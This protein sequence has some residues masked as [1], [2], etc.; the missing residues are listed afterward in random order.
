MGATEPAEP[1]EDPHEAEGS[2]GGNASAQGSGGGRLAE[3]D[4]CLS[5]RGGAGR[6][7]QDFLESARWLLGADAPGLVCR[8]EAVAYCVREAADSI[9][10]S[11]GPVTVDSP[12]K[13]LSQRVVD[14]R[15]RYD[16]AVRFPGEGSSEAALADLLG[17]IDALEEF[18]QEW[19]TLN[20]V[21][22][23]EVNARL[24]GSP[25]QRG[26][27]APMFE[28]LGVHER[29]SVF[30][31]SRSSLEDAER[32]LW[33]CVDSMLGLLRSPSDRE[34]QMAEV[35]A[36]ACPG[37]DDLAEALRRIGT[38][39]DLDVFLDR[40]C[41]PAWLAL[42]NRDG[43]LDPP[44]GGDGR[45]A[46][47]RAAVRLSA[48][49]RK[50]VTDWLVS[51]VEQRPGD[52]D[53]CT[54]VVGA[55]LNMEDPD[56]GLALRFAASHY[57]SGHM[58]WF[59]G[60]ALEDT[61]PSDAIVL[62]CADVFLNNLAV[63]EDQA[64]RA[65]AS[66]WDYMPW[67]LMALLR[68]VAEGA[69]EANAADRIE[70]LLHKLRR[71][72]LR[73]GDLGLYPIGR[74]WLIPISAL[75]ECDLDENTAYDEDP[76]HALGDCLVSIMGKAMAWLPAAELLDL[77]GNAPEGL[78]GRLRTWI[79]AEAPDADPDAMT[80]E[81]EQ[82]ITSRMPNC[83]DI[84]LIDRVARDAGLHANCD[85]WKAALGD[86][87]TQAEARQA[88]ESP[89][90]L[91]ER[92][93]CP[94]LWS[95]LLP[96]AAAEAW[97]GAPGPLA[98]AE[99]IGPPEDRGHYAA[100]QENP[101]RGGVWAGPV[102]PPLSAED[103]RGMGPEW[104]AAEIAAWRPQRL[105]WPHSYRLIAAEIGKLVR[106]DPA[107]WL[108]D[109][110]KIAE[111]VRHPT[112]IAAYLRAA[113]RAAA[114]SPDAFDTVA[115]GGL[116]DAVSLAQ[117]EPW[118]AEHFDGDIRPQLDYDPDWVPAR[119]AGTALAESLL[120]SGVGLG[121]R[122]DDVWDYLEAEART[123]PRIFDA[124]LRGPGFADDPVGHMLDNP[125]KRNTAAD[126]RYLAI[127]QANTEAV[128][129][130]LS[131][132]SYEHEA[133][134]AVRPGAVELIE[135]C[136]RQPGLEGAKH[137]AIIAP[138]AGFLRRIMADWFDQN[139]SLLF[140]GDAPGRL[141]QLSVD[142]AVKVSQPW[143]WLLVNYRD[144][145][146][147]SAA[148]GADRS[149]HWLMAAMLCRID[150]YRPQHLTQKL[151]ESIPQ[152]CGAL[153]GLT[154]TAEKT[155]EQM[156]ALIS[157][158]NAVTGYRNG[159]HATALGRLAYADTLDHGTWADITLKAL[160]KTG[161]QIS[162]SHAIAKRILDNPPSPEGASILTWL[163]EVQT[164]PARPQTEDRQDGSRDGTYPRRLIANGAADWL[165]TAQ[166]REPGDEYS[167]LEAK[168]SD[169]GLLARTGPPAD[170]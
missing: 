19:P 156:E 8:G 13:D 166:H 4:D 170:V 47:H 142:L 150:G 62:E 108:A 18:K 42:L 75:L 85:R 125:G 83:D 111:A 167:R 57:D 58:V 39:R 73:Y 59:F 6:R 102:P 96:E 60:R 52:R 76:G 162:Q 10:K 14:A 169:H 1:S 152:A 103:L 123:N 134:R 90:P 51:I 2:A 141:G 65:A 31:H 135:W 15:Y 92:W 159:R 109:P 79:L 84:A 153:A 25:A 98:L 26:D 77:A 163:V 106:A 11:A 86:P 112:Y 126:P 46:A 28:F 94:Y 140:G 5:R 128:D 116:V 97:A 99:E 37:D 63:T 127:N 146:Y 113:A 164:N 53:W 143:D 50:Q 148:R 145:I 23:A 118:P 161:G 154:D 40:I 49:H 100:L 147:D 27:L 165:N 32:L 54:A 12:W 9:L 33:E 69:D 20:E 160:H 71:M 48:S 82:A 41:D 131:F 67:D 155:P 120:R 88:L 122:D 139:H 16:Q 151:G 89:E 101:D 22:A 124:S 119:R 3:L 129:V 144:S 44:N 35:A 115:V 133:T 7:A 17:E 68:M 24:T 70:M 43:R 29:A 80:A 137:R 55:L 158:C 56:I 121:G 107:G 91:P 36:W 81:I 136:L 66:G 30:L 93:L 38:D 114:D 117:A 78:A 105:D 64:G 34:A 95:S 168:L 110:L 104:A 72:P 87:P 157:F 149:F 61:D 74:D 138:A 132:V 130:A 21:R 45:W